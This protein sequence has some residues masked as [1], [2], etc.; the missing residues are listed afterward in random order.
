MILRRGW[1]CCCII[2]TLSTMVWQC[3]NYFTGLENTVIEYKMFNEMDTDMYPSIGL[4]WTMAINEELLKRYGNK[5][6]SASYLYFLV[7]HYWDEDMLAVDYE[8]VTPNFD[9]YIHRYGYI[10][11]YWEYKDMYN[12]AKG[13]KMKPGFK[14]YSAF[15][16]RC[17]TI[18]IPFKKDIPIKEDRQIHGFYVF[19]DSSIFGGGMRLA[20]PIGN[21]FDEKQ[22]IV[23]L[24]YPQQLLGKVNF[25]I[26]HW[27]LRVPSSP[28]GYLI[29]MA[30]GDIEVSV[31]RNTNHRPCI[32]GV[33]D[34]DETVMQ[35][36]M[37][38][39]KCKPPYWNSTSLFAPCTEQKQLKVV[40]EVLSDA[41]NKGNRG[42]NDMVTPPCRSLE[43]VHYDVQD[44]ETP[45]K[46][47]KEYPWMNT[48]VGVIFEFKEFFYKEVKSVRGMDVQAL[49]G[50]FQVFKF[51]NTSYIKY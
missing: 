32:E 7:G 39:A 28:K 31:R 51:D 6:T 48:S 17:F 8:G 44:V 20:N 27:P 41:I 34:Y 46:W 14:D 26:R 2:A 18:D 30:V 40:E 29:R 25:G 23:T 37:K 47:I 12:K 19:F 24:H 50:K 21:G 45:E 9:E 10:N 42:I 11:A 22:F 5:F 1:T 15:T 16:H 33:P 43:M 3:S 4:C 38:K 49:I 36:A 35:S 13:T